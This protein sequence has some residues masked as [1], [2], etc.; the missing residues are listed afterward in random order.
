MYIFKFIYI[1]V[2]VCMYECTN[3]CMVVR[4]C[5]HRLTAL[6]R[7]SEQNLGTFTRQ[8]AAFFVCC[9]QAQAD[10]TSDDSM[11]PAAHT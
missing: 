11:N 3:V 6:A 1:C 10:M 7:S 5:V 2:Y 8:V 4:V 9:E